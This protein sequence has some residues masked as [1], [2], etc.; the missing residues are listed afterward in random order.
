MLINWSAQNT[1]V[2]IFQYIYISVFYQLAIQQEV[3][4][5]AVLEIFKRFLKAPL[6]SPRRHGKRVPPPSVTKAT[7]DWHRVVNTGT[8]S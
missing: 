8:A 4:Q 1:A 3:S 2:I 7:P 6:M 5:I